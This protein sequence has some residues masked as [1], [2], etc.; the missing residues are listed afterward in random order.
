MQQVDLSA[1]RV[2]QKVRGFGA[3]GK[4]CVAV[5]TIEMLRFRPRRPVQ[6]V[7]SE[8]KTGEEGESG[9]QN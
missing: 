1:R 7:E 6:D 4:P 9:S 2:F 3:R 8:Y 5:G